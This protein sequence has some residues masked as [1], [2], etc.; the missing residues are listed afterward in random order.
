MPIDEPGLSVFVGGGLTPKM[1]DARNYAHI[2]DFFDRH[3]NDRPWVRLRERVL[4]TKEVVDRSRIIADQISQH[5]VGAGSHVGILIDNSPE[6]I[7]TWLAVCRLGGCAVLLPWAMPAGLLKRYFKIAALDAII[8]RESLLADSSDFEEVHRLDRDESLFFANAIGGRKL[9]PATPVASDP[10]SIVFTSGSSGNPKGALFSHRYV[11]E[12]GHTIAHGKGFQEGERMFFCNPLYH[13][14]GVWAIFVSLI[15]HGELHLAPRFSVSTFWRDVTEHDSTWFP[16][17]GASLSFLAKHPEPRERPRHKLRF[18][19]GGGAPAQV[20]QAFEDRFG[21]PVLEA[22]SQTE[23]LAC[24]SNNV[25]QRKTGTNGRPY[26]GVEVRIV[27]AFD[28]PVPIGEV[29]EIVA[30]PPR[31]FMTFSGYFGNAE[32]TSKKSLNLFHRTND[33]GSMDE[34]GYITFRGRN[35]S[36]IRRRGENLIPEQIETLVEG[37]SWVKK[38]AAVGVASE[39]GDQDI[40]ILATIEEPALPREN[41]VGQ[42]LD[43]LPRIMRPRWLEIVDQ[44]PL[45][46]TNKLARGELPGTPGS[47]AIVID[48]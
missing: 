24:C 39:Y 29:G 5:G 48:Q 25:D 22:F 43:I 21:V 32:E 46:A 40:L 35:G 11:L 19:S 16:Y 31:P 8:Y 14:D 47:R 13:G 33:L 37:L 6:F 41:M 28:H 38:A 42:C 9:A 45:T 1:A 4:T 36:M 27:D 2:S 30:R 18:T 12:L 3:A 15:V 44:L 23:C 7:V 20:I 26:P 10:A 17:I 34:D